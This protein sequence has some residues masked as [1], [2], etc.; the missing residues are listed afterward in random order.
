MKD[1]DDLLRAM[2]QEDQEEVLR[3]AA[4]SLPPGSSAAL[5]AGCTC[6]VYDNAHGAGMGRDEHGRVVYVMDWDCPLHGGRGRGA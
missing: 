4:R 2:P 6:P 1:F 3:E 5:E